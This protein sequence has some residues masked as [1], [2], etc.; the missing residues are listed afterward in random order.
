M[1]AGE[2]QFPSGMQTASRAP[3]DCLSPTHIQLA[4]SELSEFKKISCEVRK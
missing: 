4:Q 2:G 1:A 3:T